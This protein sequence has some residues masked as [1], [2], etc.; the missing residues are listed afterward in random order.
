VFIL[1]DHS[2]RAFIS[3]D[4]TTVFGSVPPDLKEI[5]EKTN[6]KMKFING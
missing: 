5:K 6:I 4:E 3:F 2:A 1:L